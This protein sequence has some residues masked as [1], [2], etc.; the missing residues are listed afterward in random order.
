MIGGTD[1]G[2][3]RHEND[4]PAAP[5][6]ATPSAFNP[7]IMLLAL[8]MGFTLSQ[9]FRTVAALMA[10]PLAA[11]LHLSP[12]QLGLF[13]ATFHFAFGA[14]QVF[15]GVGIDLHGVRRTV[16]V[17]FPLAVAGAVLCALAPD[18]R[19]ILAGQAL[20]GV[21]CAPAFLVCTVFIARHFPVA[22]FA[23]VSGTVMSLGGVGM[24][25]T[26]TP[27]AWLIDRYS[28][29]AGFVALAVGSALA[30]AVMWMVVREPS[31]QVAGAGSRESLPEALRRFGQLLVMPHTA[32]IFLLS[33]VT[34]AS[35]I[36]LRGLWLGPMLT[37]Q[38]GLSLV[39]TG[40][41]ALVLSL[42]ALATPPLFGRLRLV[43]M[44]RRRWIVRFA[45][46][47]AALFVALALIHSALAT[48]AIALAIGVLSGFIVLQYSDVRA[49]YPEAF[50]GRAMAVF[51]M[52]MFLGIA[53]MQWLTGLVAS[54]AHA[55]GH[56]PFTAVNLAVAAMLALGAAAFR[57]L[58]SSVAER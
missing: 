58:P 37:E 4:T 8:C 26:G 44:E 55:Q 32:G 56:E 48:I 15:M 17:A 19:W 31:S 57:F 35:F 27:L 53:L 29:R 7:W 3:M 12:A 2:G 10:P 50:T 6:P 14:M 20:I 16:L 25:L 41:V 9:A 36:A 24:L 13:A 54:V 45:S 33:G 18:V 1:N 5:A 34:Y 11:E 42:I 43:G 38:Y 23:A 52:A 49:S 28:W 47:M 51:T 40:N 22:R 21:G 46:G 30:W 39:Q